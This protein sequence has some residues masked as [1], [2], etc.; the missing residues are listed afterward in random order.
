MF[1][2]LSLLILV[3]APVVAYTAGA[4]M[5]FVYELLHKDS[6]QPLYSE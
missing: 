4:M 5:F 3:L 2:T 1:D 6:A